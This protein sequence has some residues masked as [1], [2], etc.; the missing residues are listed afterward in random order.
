MPSAS[1]AAPRRHDRK[2]YA[3]LLSLLTP[4]LAASGPLRD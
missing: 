4:V 1:P 3:W 2:R